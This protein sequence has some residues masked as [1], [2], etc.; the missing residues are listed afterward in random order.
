VLFDTVRIENVQVP[1]GFVHLSGVGRRGV[2]QMRRKRGRA[3]MV[4]LD[5]RADLEEEMMDIRR[6]IV[7]FHGEMLLLE[8]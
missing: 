4:P 8:N 1:L 5:C 3:G 7:N 2:R 6:D